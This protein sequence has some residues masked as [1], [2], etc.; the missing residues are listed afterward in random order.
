MLARESNGR[1]LACSHEA[2]EVGHQSGAKKYWISCSHHSAK[3]SVFISHRL[4][5]VFKS[6]RLKWRFHTILM[7]YR[8]NTTVFCDFL[9]PFSFRSG[10]CERGLTVLVPILS[11][12][13]AY[14][15]VFNFPHHVIC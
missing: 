10:P 8:V 14:N 7:R 4:G 5:I 3:G 12:T 9:A 2:V 1:V 6:L 11:Q 15:Y 13:K